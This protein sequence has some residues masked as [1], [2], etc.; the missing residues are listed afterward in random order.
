MSDDPNDCS[1]GFGFVE[2]VNLTDDSRDDAFVLIWVLSEDILDD[3]GGFLHD[4]WD[5]SVDKFEKGV[6]ALTSSRFDLDCELAYGTYSFSHELH[7]Y[8]CCIFSE[9]IENDCDVVFGGEHEDEF[10]F[11]DFNVDWIVVF[12]EEY[13]NVV[14]QYF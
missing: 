2:I 5:A 3:T 7:V 6:D 10:E 11:G 8:F 12:A 14:W 9:F 13:S 4:I 1:F